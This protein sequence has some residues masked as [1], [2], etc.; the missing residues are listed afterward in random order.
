[1]RQISAG[2]PRA[3]EGVDEA[4]RLR[5]H[6]M[7]HRASI[8]WIAI[9]AASFAATPRVRL[10]PTFLRG[11]TL[12]YQIEIST[13]T[14]GKTTAP[15]A[16]NEGA[17]QTSL[18]IA[19]REKLQILSVAPS[20]AGDITGIRL[21]WDEAQASSTSDALDP[22][23]SDPAAP[24]NALE[25]QSV[26]FTLSADG[27]LKNFSG[28]EKVMPGGVPPPESV[29]WI[30]SLV[31]ANRFPRGGVSVGQQW[32]SESAIAGAPLAGLFWV[33]KSTYQ[34][35]EPCAPASGTQQP[36]QGS[37]QCALI[38]GQ[39]SIERHS[40]EHSNGHGNGRGDDTPEDYLH[41]G[42][43]TAGTW[44]GTG[45]ELGAI[46]V[47]NGILVNTTENS[48]QSMDYEIRSATTGSAIHYVAKVETQTGIALIEDAR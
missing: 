10:T 37:L 36:S 48:T 45:G 8:A 25:G 41:N 35:N 7:P 42:L 43:R 26:E 11:E 31:G 19:L 2:L 6:R 16:N 15:I 21:T 30:E 12:T 44:T 38:I 24:F 40:S 29:A 22:T 3:G 33:T 5:L 17:T 23:A 28:L 27:A 34:H 4:L 47:S 18:N 13:E 20:S 46:D 9:A 39:M 32:K 14:A 1:M